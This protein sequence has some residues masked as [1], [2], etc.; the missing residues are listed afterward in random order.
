MNYKLHNLMTYHLTISL[1]NKDALYSN[2]FR[3]NFNAPLQLTS[4]PGC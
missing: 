2:V 1:L 4:P 3:H